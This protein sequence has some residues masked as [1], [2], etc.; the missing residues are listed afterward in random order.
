MMTLGNFAATEPSSSSESLKAPSLV[1]SEEEARQEAE[2]QRQWN[3]EH[4]RKREVECR[5]L[6]LQHESGNQFVA[7]ESV[8]TTTSSED[9]TVEAME[10]TPAKNCNSKE[11]C[12]CTDGN[13]T[14]S[15][16][17]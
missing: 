5:E 4:R 13:W 16:C 2:A 7:T 15:Q 1:N 3:E 6:E 17:G 9:A 8:V 14:T 11:I 10:A 12:S